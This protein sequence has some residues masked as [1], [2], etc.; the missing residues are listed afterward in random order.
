MLNAFH[1]VCWMTP[2]TSTGM[3]PEGGIYHEQKD[4]T[5]VRDDVSMLLASLGTHTSG[6]RLRAVCLHWHSECNLLLRGAVVCS[7]QH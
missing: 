6:G 7:P 4:P 2:E 1:L 5:K 3:K